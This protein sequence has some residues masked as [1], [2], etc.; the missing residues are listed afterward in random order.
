MRQSI[1]DNFIR[2]HIGGFGIQRPHLL[3]QLLQAC[4]MGIQNMNFAVN[5][6][7]NGPV[8][9]VAIQIQLQP[10]IFRKMRRTN[11]R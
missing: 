6:Q 5:G 8:N 2:S 4:L 10:L 1:A 3:H 9:L 7:R 11:S